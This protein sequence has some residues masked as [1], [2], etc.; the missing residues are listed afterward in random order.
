MSTAPLRAS[1]ERTVR[2]L[3]RAYL[4]IK[5]D[6]LAAGHEWEIAWQESVRIESVTPTGFL[7]EAA[8]V[9]FSAGM[10]EAV[11]RAKF[12]QLEQA[13]SGWAPDR[14]VARP[15]RCRSAALGVFGHKRKVDAVIEIASTVVRDGVDSIIAGVVREGPG[16]LL[17]LPFI[18]PVTCFHLAKNLG[19]SVAK[20]DRHLE[21][22]ASALNQP[23]TSTLCGIISS[24]LDEPVQVVDLVIWRYATIDHNYI[25]RFRQEFGEAYESPDGGWSASTAL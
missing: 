16:A 14:I 5:A 10:R 15:A 25:A 13:F 4:L 19:C 11:V 9:V 21:R 23:G 1:D 3:A 2:A 12:Q 24:Y 17:G 18:G 8:W 6:V 20:P 22:V 7:R